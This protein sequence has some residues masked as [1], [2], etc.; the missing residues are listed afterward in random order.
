MVPSVT[1][2]THFNYGM[3]TLTL[4]TAALAPAALGLA[5]LSSAHSAS[6]MISGN[7]NKID[8]ASGSAQVVPDAQPDSL[9][10]LDFAQFP[11]SLQH[12][13]NVPNTVIGPPSNIAIHPTLPLALIANSVRLDPA[14][15]TGF[16]PESQIHI[17]DLSNQPPKILGEVQVGSQPSGMSFTP[18]GRL[19]LVANR[20]AGS[21]SVLQ[22]RG[23]QISVSQTLTVCTPEES[24]SDVAVHPNGKL[25]LV[26]IQ[27]GGYL[28]VLEISGGQVQ[29]TDRKIS[30][31]GQPYRCVITPDGVLGL[32]AGQ[33]AG[34]GLDADA[35]TVVDLE[36]R[37]IRTVDYV[38]LGAVPESFEVSP[39][40]KLL[41]AVV[42]NGSNLAPDA[43][44]YQPHGAVV[45]LERQDRTFRKVQTLPI[46]RI[47]EGV[48]FSPDGRHL[49]VQCHPARQL[50]VLDVQ[51][52]RLKDAGLRL[53]VPG[54]PSSLRAAR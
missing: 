21:V 46:G 20:A 53:S 14:S 6:W 25:A 38:A 27:K 33:G 1:H 18:D 15:P 43:T 11:P 36:A 41:A 16:V 51:N 2:S 54:M 22:I 32:T 39:D 34:N 10:L 9:T 47:P 49:V 4:K 17:L 48:A 37:P 8:L 3:S 7:E 44:H 31:Y 40:G 45:L 13:T 42:M 5:L 26:S 30:V 52:H 23:P 12:L 35:L 29:V 24:A 28:Q 19:A 50:W